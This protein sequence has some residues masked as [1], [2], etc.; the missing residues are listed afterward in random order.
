MD[1]ILLSKQ[2]YLFTILFLVQNALPQEIFY[3]S[4]Q[5]GINLSYSYSTS[6]KTNG[7]TIG[8]SYVFNGTLILA[9]AYLTSTS[10]LN[11]RYP[12]TLDG[13]GY[14]IGLGFLARGKKVGSFISSLLSIAYS[15]NTFSSKYT[16]DINFTSINLGL[17]IFKILNI[18]KSL[19]FG[20]E[21]HA[22]YSIVSASMDDFSWFYSGSINDS[23]NIFSYGLGLNFCIF[24]GKYF[25]PSTILS[26]S[27]AEGEWLTNFGLSISIGNFSQEL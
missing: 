14:G 26:F 5:S 4:S 27:N 3:E 17:S 6:D 19:K 1:D 18:S 25:K 11:F 12:K 16:S 7:S 23:E 2:F 10:E 15:S 21:L 22:G 8:G 13:S 24:E 9:G 20:P